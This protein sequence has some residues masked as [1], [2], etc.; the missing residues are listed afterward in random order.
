MPCN[1]ALATDGLGHGLAAWNRGLATK[2]KRNK[3]TDTEKKRKKERKSPI[4][5]GWGG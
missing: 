5:P 3:Q 2:K 4:V 1:L